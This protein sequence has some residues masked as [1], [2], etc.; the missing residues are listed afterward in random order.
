MNTFEVLAWFFFVIVIS[1]LFFAA[2][3]NSK[4]DEQSIEEYMDKLIA[5]E[6]QRNNGSP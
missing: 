5:E 2:F 3:G 1:L 6:R 4:Y